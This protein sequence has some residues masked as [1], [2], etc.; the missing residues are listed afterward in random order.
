MV[1]NRYE[2]VEIINI[3]AADL[4]LAIERFERFLSRPSRRTSMHE[5]GGIGLSSKPGIPGL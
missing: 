1:F 3:P 2:R 4:Q 5:L